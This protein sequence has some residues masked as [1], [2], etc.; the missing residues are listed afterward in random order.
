MLP[1]PPPPR[2][3]AEFTGAPGTR[4]GDFTGQ[5]RRLGA[6]AERFRQWIGSHAVPSFL[7]I[8]PAWHARCDVPRPVRGDA[9]AGLAPLRASFPAGDKGMTGWLAFV[10]GIA[11]LVAAAYLLYVVLRP[12]AF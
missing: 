12:E 9:V 1:R 6:S 2:S 11:V 4:H 7:P 5:A 10:C 8:K 3:Y